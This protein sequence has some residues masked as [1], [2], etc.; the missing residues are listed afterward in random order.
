MSLAAWTLAATWQLARL[1]R[2][3]QYCGALATDILP[4]LGSDTSSINQAVGLISGSMRSHMRHCM[5]IGPPGGLVH[6]LL[7]V[8]F[9][10]VR[11]PSSHGLNR[12]AAA[13]ELSPRR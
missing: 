9:V 11:Q 7:Q 5:G 12:L 6:E 1:P 2:A 3:P 8:L 13:V 10:A 4:S